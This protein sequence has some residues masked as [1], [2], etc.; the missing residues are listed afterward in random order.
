MGDRG[1]GRV[2]YE[3][4]LEMPHAVHFCMEVKL[5]VRLLYA[6]FT[7]LVFDLHVCFLQI[8]SFAGM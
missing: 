4:C 8:E 7:S 1:K 5:M 2:L 3:G 6:A